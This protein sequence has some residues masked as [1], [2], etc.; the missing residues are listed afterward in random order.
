MH[1]ETE[2]G[3][4]SAHATAMGCIIDLRY[5]RRNRWFHRFEFRQPFRQRVARA[6]RLQA[7]R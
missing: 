2:V 4:L 3:G 7:T 6:R 1:A 5:R